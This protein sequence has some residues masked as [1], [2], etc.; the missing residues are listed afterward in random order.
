MGET[1]VY[2]EYSAVC[3]RI[4]DLSSRIYYELERKFVEIKLRKPVT[5]E[6]EIINPITFRKSKVTVKAKKVMISKTIDIYT[7]ENRVV[8]INTFVSLAYNIGKVI[9]K[10]REE[11]ESEGD[12]QQLQLLDQIMV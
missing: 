8:S 7:P 11:L 2:S 6:V 1:S 12:K 10:L 9:D 4:F 5:I 3:D